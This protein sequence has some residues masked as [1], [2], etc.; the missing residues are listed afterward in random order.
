MEEFGLNPQK[1]LA[2]LFTSASPQQAGDEEE[3]RQHPIEILLVEDNPADV[4][5]MR[6][7]LFL[8]E[9]R[10]NLTVV[11]DGEEALT[12]LN[13]QY[14]YAGSPRPDIVVLDIKLPRVSGHEVLEG[15]R[16]NPELQTLPVMM[17]T[18]SYSTQDRSTSE[19]LLATHYVTKPVGL[20]MLAGEIKIINALVK[21]SGI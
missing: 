4:R 2:R 6:E 14:P 15:I 17:L 5:M 18:S 20:N 7:A 8:A 16:K 3:T 13:R 12:Y 1:R 10:H 11:T 19:R 21:R 9:I